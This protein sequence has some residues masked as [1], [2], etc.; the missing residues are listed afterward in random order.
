[1]STAAALARP[2]A[3]AE[4]PVDALIKSIRIPPRP[5]LLADLQR[6]LASE[7]PSPAAIGRIVAS[8]VGMSGA[9]LKLANSTCCRRTPPHPRRAWT[10]SPCACCCCA[11]PSRWC[12]SC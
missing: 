4:D 5:S 10:A 11:V 9:L 3:V 2:S 12:C 6:E 7:D 1:M 8:D